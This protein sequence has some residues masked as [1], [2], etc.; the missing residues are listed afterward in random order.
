MRSVSDQLGSVPEP[1]SVALADRVRQLKA[2]GQRVIALQ[3][4][5][6]DFATPEA[7]M[8]AA[9]RAMLNGQTHYADSRGLPSLRRDIATKLRNVNAVDCDPSDEILVTCGGVHAYYCAL[10]S[11]VDPGDEVLVPDPSWMT[12]ANLVTVA[13]GKAIRVPAPSETGFL[14]TLAAWEKALSP[15]TVALVVNSPNN[16]TGAV[17]SAPYLTQL[18]EFAAAHDL[19]VISDEVYENIV[20]SGAQHTCFASLPGAKERTLL[21]NS[22]SK[23]YAM[24]GWRIG[25]LVAPAPVISLAL[26]ASQHSVTNVAPFIQEAASFALTSPAMS[27]ASRAMAESYTHRREMV[28]ELARARGSGPVHF[29]E[30]QGAFY[31]LVDIRRLGLLSVQVAERLLNEAAIAMVPGSAFGDYGEGFLRMTIAAADAD[32]VEGV[33]GFLEWAEAQA[34][35]RS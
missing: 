27:L 26:K 28:L 14:P 8:E 23:T 32:I 3:T 12:H 24:T 2:A 20:Y 33:S 15:R 35:L 4:G 21:V 19:W 7:I 17:A 1:A 30:P 22:F 13:G 6:P 29:V 9:H 18:N 11:I 31:F 5:D 25:Y 16:P 34:V 10:R